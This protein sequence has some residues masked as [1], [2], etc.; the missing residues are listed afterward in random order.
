MPA[1]IAEP[2]RR[3]A[4]LTVGA[5]D[6]AAR[7]PVGGVVP[8]AVVA[9]ERPEQVAELLALA[10]TH[11]W[12]VEIAGAA[13][14]LDAGR[15]PERVDL[16]I[17]T[18]RLCDVAEY[19]PADL[20]IGVGAGL[21]VD[22]LQREVGRNRQCLMLDPPGAV[23]STMGAT[24]ATASAGPLRHAFGAPRDHALGLDVVTGDGRLLHVGG[25]V[26]KNV[27]GYDLVRLVVGSRG[28][29]GVIT[30]LHVRLRPEPARDATVALSAG[31]P[32]PL[33]E[34][35]AA[36]LTRVRPVALELFSAPLAQ[37]AAGVRAWTLLA[38]LQ[39]NDDAVRDAHQ[40][41]FDLA[42]GLAASGHAP[43]ALVPSEAATAWAMLRELEGAGSPMIRL[44]DQPSRLAATLEVALRIAARSGAVGP[45]AEGWHLAAHAGDGIVRLW[46]AGALRN[47]AET[48][49]GVLEARRALAPEGGT[50]AVPHGAPALDRD[51]EPYVVDAAA[52]RLMRAVKREFDPAGILAPGRFVV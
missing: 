13:T 47:G 7:H 35:L 25:R 21:S 18:A 24:F 30:R 49:A 39:G 9:P 46:P 19:E 52:L 15:R 43:R 3:I 10:S 32:A 38:R 14:W 27:A 26:V 1:S 12:A 20:T 22:A 11:G 42:A 50:V 8:A 44:A 51:L 5:P 28:T 17:A 2:L 16:L 4:G 36:I 23:A 33:L 37:R 41:L 6:D 48:T 45:D 40:R 34:L 29:L 31:Q